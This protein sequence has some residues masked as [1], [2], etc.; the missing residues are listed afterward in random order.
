MKIGLV[1]ATIAGLAVSVYLLVDY[2]LSDVWDALLTAGWEGFAAVTIAH[3]VAIALCALAWRTLIAAAPPHAY[4]AF[5]WARFLRD[6]VNNLVGIVPCAGEMVGAR[7]L[8]LHGVPSGM[9]AAT[10]VI[11]VTTELLSQLAFALLGLG[12][13]IYV[14][15]GGESAW[16]TGAGIAG[17]T[18]IL[19]GF[20]LAQRNDLFRFV[21]TLPSRLGLVQQWDE[22]KDAAPV[23]AAIQDIYRQRGR[24]LAA[25]ATHFV[26]WL[27]RSVEA[28]TALYLMNQSLP[29][30]NIIAIEAIVYALR[31]IAFA[32]PSAIG[33]QEGGYV[34]IGAIF[35]L[36]PDTALA[37]SLLKRAREVAL[38]LPALMVWQFLE[39]QRLLHGIGMHTGAR[40]ADNI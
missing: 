28:I 6:G 40:K 7:E 19:V 14:Q 1:F 22:T 11:D 23:H 18:I 29:V 20:I 31:T 24:I 27:A 36:G 21:E 26:A 37:L 3:L 8:R 34:L 15:P 38:G 13:L 9:A 30:L 16:W 32:V 25:I 5:F 2:G 39:T 33:V 35:G 12:V 10:T 17:A 4:L